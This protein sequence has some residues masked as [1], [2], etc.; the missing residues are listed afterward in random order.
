MTR[1][2]P[3]CFLAL[4]I[5]ILY[6]PLSEFG[7]VQDDRVLIRGFLSGG[8]P[9]LSPEGKLFFRPF[10]WLYC[11]SVY[12]IFGMNG[13]GFHLGFLHGGANGLITF[14]WVHSF[15]G[16]EKSAPI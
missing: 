13:I 5:V 8:V 16:H 10:G 9:N 4:A 6:S 15:L 11:Y 2:F 1:Y 12:Q 3:Y 14:C 7:Y